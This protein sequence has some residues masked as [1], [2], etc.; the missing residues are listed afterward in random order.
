MDA[1]QILS[2][3]IPAL[4]HFWP[5]CPH[6]EC[7]ARQQEYMESLYWGQAG[8]KQPFE[9]TQPPLDPSSTFTTSSQSPNKSTPLRY[10]VPEFLPRSKKRPSPGLFLH[11]NPASDQPMR[12]TGYGLDPLDPLEE[13]PLPPQRTLL[14]PV[15][16]DLSDFITYQEA[17]NL[18]LGLGFGSPPSEWEHRSE[19]FWRSV[20]Q[21]PDLWKEKEQ[22]PQLIIKSPPSATQKL[23]IPDTDAYD[24]SIG[25]NSGEDIALAHDAL[26]DTDAGCPDLVS[27]SGDDDQAD[28]L[29]D[30]P[31]ETTSYVTAVDIE[32]LFE[33]DELLEYPESL[34][35]LS[36]GTDTTDDE[37]EFAG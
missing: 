10:P 13:L 37:D 24:Y 32:N 14:N 12:H 1:T 31:S 19:L 34:P 18:G 30:S 33:S 5:Q 15:I 20:A 21:I 3:M 29:S 2:V 8:Q 17:L 4:H 26:E 35:D 7:V 36:C 27:D 28:Q 9:F 23:E 11:H 22:G 16:G 6:Q 25:P